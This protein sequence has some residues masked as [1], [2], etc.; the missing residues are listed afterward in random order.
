VC[1]SDVP[2]RIVFLRTS[3]RVRRTLRELQE[4][5]IFGDYLDFLEL[6]V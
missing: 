4:D 1:T 5:I 6:G 2:G 3:H